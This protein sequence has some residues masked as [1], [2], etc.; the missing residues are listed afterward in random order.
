MRASVLC[1]SASPS[2]PTGPT[3]PRHTW[4]I[5]GVER[6]TRRRI[7]LSITI[8]GSRIVADFT[9]YG[10]N[11]EWAYQPPRDGRHR[12]RQ[13][14]AEVD[15]FAAGSRERWRVPRPRSHCPG[16]HD[17]QSARASALRLLRLRVQRHRRADAARPRAIAPEK[18]PAGSGQIFGIYLF[19]VDHRGGEPFIMIDATTVG[20]GGRPTGD[21]PNLIFVVDGDTPNV[22]AEIIE[23]RYPVLNDGAQL[24]IGSAGAGRFRGGLG[25]VREF[26]V[27]EDYV[28]G[29][30]VHGEPPRAPAGRRRRRGGEGPRASSS[31]RAARTRRSSSSA[32]PSAGRFTAASASVRKGRWRRLGRPPRA[33]PGARTRGRP[34]R[35]R[36]R[37]RGCRRLRR[38]IA[39]RGRRRRRGSDA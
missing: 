28:S 37:R 6:E 4:T 23:S 25:V 17:H 36:P 3:A 33:R 8:D 29:A 11:G 27:L 1:A 32:S 34:R 13:C 35:V 26:E 39:Q 16:G 30:G 22:P 24:N 20:W 7:A 19:R 2:Y 5:D 18:C 10:S 14:R 12:R 31:A 15:S 21:G 9:G 38:G